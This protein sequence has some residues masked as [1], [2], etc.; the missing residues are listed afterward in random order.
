M[1]NTF[2]SKIPGNKCMKTKCKVFKQDTNQIFTDRE[3]SVYFTGSHTTFFQRDTVYNVIRVMKRSAGDMQDF[4]YQQFNLS[5]Y[6]VKVDGSLYSLI[7][8][9]SSIPP[10]KH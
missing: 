3:Q 7:N 6:I 10:R 4:L 2:V 5:A 1:N 9:T 8:S